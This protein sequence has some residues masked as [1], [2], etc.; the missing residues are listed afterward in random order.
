M[1]RGLAAALCL[2]IPSV[3][4]A[5]PA[6]PDTP[7]G[8]VFG[9]WLTSFNDADRAAIQVFKDKYKRRTPVDA[10]LEQREDTG[11]F[12][13]VR[14]ETQEPLALTAILRERSAPDA[15]YRFAIS[16]TN[17]QP[18]SINKV[19]FE[20]LPIPRMSEADAL[21]SL[22]ARTRLFADK[23]QFSG[24]LLVARH[25]KVLLEKAYGDADRAKGTPNTIDTQFRYASLGK[26]F[27]AIATLQLVEAGKLSLD[28]HVGDY[29]K[30]YPNKE[31]ASKVTIRHLLTHTSG[32][33][34]ISTLDWSGFK[35]P[36]EF[37]AYRDQV[38]THSDYVQ[39]HGTRAPEFEPGSKVEY[40]NYAFVLLGTIIER[41]SGQNY[42]DY[43]D[44]HVLAPAGMTST[45]NAPE[46]EVLPRRAVGYMR[47]D[48]A[49]VPNSDTLPYRGMAAGGGYTT[50][51]DMLRFAQALQSGKL[52]SKRILAEATKSQMHED[53]YGFGFITVGTGPTR[54]YGHGG[55]HNGMNADFRVFPE[56]GYV[57]VSLSNL[58][59]P[60][61][62]RP[63]NYIE[64]RMP[65]E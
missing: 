1:I 19:E 18:A 64:P 44:K 61:A 54:R 51:G 42:Y 36:K 32:A 47:K 38:R 57:L 50:V 49:W 17:G 33:G 59:P 11:G 48:N 7:A 40:S 10:V 46:T 63:L 58:D 43:I 4:F 23:E 30:D 56:S 25:G 12:D 27:T 65:I 13:V 62:N 41:I 39:R 26:M 29:L 2:L 52:L 20:D 21:A 28:G 16:V 60:S 35:S 14:L 37:L 53:W 55:D 8:K 9:E 34:G 31:M 5:A 22:E 15:Q 6:I 45:G 24:T 3:T